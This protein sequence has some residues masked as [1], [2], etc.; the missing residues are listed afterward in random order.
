MKALRQMGQ[1]TGKYGGGGQGGAD[2]ILGNE[3]EEVGG[4]QI[5]H[6]YNK[7]FWLQAGEQ[8]IS[9]QETK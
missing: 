8:A 2:S 1:R 6:I 4:G 9:Q 7:W 5:L 3:E